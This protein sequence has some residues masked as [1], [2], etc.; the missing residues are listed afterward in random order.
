M[1]AMNNSNMTNNDVN[2]TGTFC[3]GL[4]SGSGEAR[5][6]RSLSSE[7]LV[8]MSELNGVKK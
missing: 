1:S 3:E 5:L 7:I 8:L 2:G 4:S 6:P